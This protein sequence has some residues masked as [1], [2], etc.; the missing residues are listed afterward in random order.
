[1]YISAFLVLIFYA[2]RV[3]K[4]Q[5]RSVVIIVGAS[6]I[7]IQMA[8]NPIVRGEYRSLRISPLV[9]ISIGI[10]YILT[11]RDSMIIIPV[12]YDQIIASV[13][14]AVLVLNTETYII[15]LNPAAERLLNVRRNHLMNRRLSA[16]LTLPSDALLHGEAKVAFEHHIGKMICEVDSLPLVSHDTV[17]GRIL[18]IRDITARKKAE[19][20]ALELAFEREQARILGLFIHDASHEFRTPITIIKSTLYLIS[21]QT[22]PDKRAQHIETI[23]HQIGRLSRLITDLQKMSA[24]DN[25]P[26]LQRVETDLI[27]VLTTHCMKAESYVEG[28]I[29]RL[30]IEAQSLVCWVDP[31]EFDQALMRLIDNAI[32]YSLPGTI[33]EVRA[34]RY[35][36]YASIEIQDHGIGMDADTLK[37]AIERFYR[38][39]ESRTTAGFG[40]G[41]P[42]AKAIIELHGG[43]LS[44]ESVVGQG[45]RVR[46]RL[47]LLAVGASI[48]APVAS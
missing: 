18:V 17:I 28:R 16:F 39:D 46:I 19:Q 34:N 13:H 7:G 12:A 35:A 20:K 2:V 15:G 27:S 24:L 38:K 1:M 9:M 22:T 45:T 30:V 37:Q 21:R 32:R 25:A 10:G 40:L 43:T 36:D 41:L 42:I 14:D 44:L 5:R 26:D 6:L 31:L 8:F 47:P 23:E 3:D 4:T 33:I 29:I 48:S 11:R